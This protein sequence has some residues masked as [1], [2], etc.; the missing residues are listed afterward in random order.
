MAFLEAAAGD[1][2]PHSDDVF[3]DVVETNSTQAVPLPGDVFN[4]PHDR[5]WVPDNS[6]TALDGPT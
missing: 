3:L 5:R 6:R 4:G 1:G 2:V